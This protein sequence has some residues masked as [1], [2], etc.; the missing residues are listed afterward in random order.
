MTRTAMLEDAMETADAPA[1]AARQPFTHRLRWFDALLVILLIATHATAVWHRLSEMPPVVTSRGTIDS[2]FHADVVRVV[3]N[4][5]DR[6]S[7]RAKSA[8]HPLFRLIAYPLPKLMVKL[9]NVSP[10]KAVHLQQSAVAGVWA[11]AFYVVLRLARCR[12]YDALLFTALACVSAAALM[13]LAV[14]ETFPYG[15][16]TIVLGLVAV[17][18]FGERPVR[19]GWLVAAGV[20]T[21]GVTVTN[22]MVGGAWTVLKARWP[23]FVQVLV[24]TFF[25]AALLWGV[26]RHFFK[27]TDFFLA[28]T[29]ESSHVM[30]RRGGGPLDKAAVFL[31]H[32]VVMPQVQ[33]YPHHRR[34]DFPIM[35]VQRS[36]PGSA[37]AWGRAGVAAWAVVLGCG[38]W[39]LVARRE[40]S[41]VCLVIALSALGQFALHLVY[42]DETFLAA[43]HFTPLLILVGSYACTT[44]LAP[45]ARAAATL[46]VV[47][48]VMNNLPVLRQ[49]TGYY[50]AGGNIDAPVL[51]SPRD[52]TSR[53]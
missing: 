17:A 37:S 14:P 27:S 28:V 6:E 4:M 7:D 12:W 26:S 44:R 41:T 19:E 38:V 36:T 52:A 11:A 45:V 25:V 46:L 32:G 20:L 23:R 9:L 39:M 18:W 24:N 35:S 10:L 8:V 34:P 30:D 33:Q 50:H 1:G 43:L 40:R 22:G 42:G 3:E 15:S 13:W 31:A 16:L 47:C 5:T 29:S 2:Y 53:R 49:V 21:F 51:P 48:A